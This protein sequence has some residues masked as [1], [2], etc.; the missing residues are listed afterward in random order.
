[1]RLMHWTFAV[2]LFTASCDVILNFNL[3]GS[4]RLAQLLM[5][6]ICMGAVA[7]V[8]QHG[9]ILWPR[10]ATAL[11]LWLIVQMLF[12]P[13]ALNF[14]IAMQFFLL[15]AFSVIGV[16]AVVQLY[17]ESERV[18]DL[19]RLYMLSFV[20][21]GAFG[22]LQLAM[23]L[24]GLPGPFVRQW[25]LHGKF[26]RIS[27][28][29][30]EP[31]YY[32]TYLFIGWIML[33]DLRISRARIAEGRFW[34]WATF[35]VGASLFL[36]TS[37]TAWIFMMVE[38]AAR[39]A[40]RILR[41][42]RAAFHQY[43]FGRIPVYLPGLRL[44][45]A[46]IGAVIG[47]VVAWGYIRAHVNPL[48]F[49]S[50]TGLA[51][52]AAH[53]YMLRF[54]AFHQTWNAFLQHPFIGHS[55]GGVAVYIASRSGIVL[56]SIAEFG[57]FWGFPV[58]LDVLVASGIF[59]F[60]PFLVFLYATTFGAMKLAR[61]FWPEEQARW[62][63]ALARAMIFEWLLLMTDQNL[64]RV[65]LWFH[66]A[67]VMLVAYHLEFVRVPVTQRATPSPAPAPLPLMGQPIVS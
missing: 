65:Y 50:G 37:K 6:L 53:S 54:D 33:L 51:G 61:R 58:L 34:K 4:V 20:A 55:L 63:R 18:E 29:S 48:I 60:I 57:R 10:G 25:I 1:M 11:L 62:L 7:H 47:A 19:M 27:G 14:A 23:P 40:P 12:V 31:S 46:F 41:G 49:L 36:S 52:T 42:L 16:F 5:I 30:Y 26:A 66:F 28:F 35:M 44:V 32:V 2:C 9:R 45:L 39:L 24:A 67:M 13:Q 43:H 8:M 59:G 17:G 3:G 22:L 64:L 15:L 21:I 38:L 56:H